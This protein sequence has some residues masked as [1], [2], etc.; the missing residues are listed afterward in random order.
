MSNQF[1]G[2]IR[3]FPYNFAPVNWAF[4][5]GQLVAIS[6]NPALFSV[7][8]TFYGGNGTSTFALPDLRGSV[9]IGSG[10]GTGLTPR[11]IGETDGVASVT[12]TSQTMAA[13][14]H[15][16]QGSINGANDTNT[17]AANATL[18]LSAPDPIYTSQS[19]DP[20]VAFSLK[21]ISPTGGSQPHENRQPFLACNYCIALQGIFPPRG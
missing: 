15:V 12:I 6:S 10:N 2:E 19:G 14:N 18:G 9:A 11:F 3:L 4:C 8:G 13:H 20:V 7:L 1:L 16:A 21:A 5:Q 17:P